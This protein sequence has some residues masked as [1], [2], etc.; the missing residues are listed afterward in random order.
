MSVIAVLIDTM[1]IQKYIFNSNYLKENLGASFIVEDIYDSQ[2]K[3]TIGELFPNIDRDNILEEW[4]KNPERIMINDENVEFEVG[5]LGGGNALLFFKDKGKAV[6]FIREWSKRLLVM[7]PGLK[8]AYA[9][10]E[11]DLSRFS[12]NIKKLFEQLRDNKNSVIPDVIIRRH[13]VS[14]ECRRTG[15]SMEVWCDKLPEGEN[16]YIS[17]ISNAKILAAEQS[18]IKVQRFLDDLKLSENYVFTDELEKL[19]Q[20][21]GEESHIAIVHIDGNDMGRRFREQSDLTNI[22]KLSK[23][24]KDATEN[25]FKNLIKEICNKFHI[26]KNNEFVFCREHNKDILPIRPIII[27]GDDITFVTDGRLG[28]YLAKIFLE[29]FERQQVSDKKPLSACAGV[30]ITKTKYPFYRGYELSEE[31]CKL[32]KERRRK[33]NDTGSWLDW[34]LVYSGISGSLSEIRDS[35]YKVLDKNLLMRPYKLTDLNE[36]IFSAKSLVIKDEKGK[37]IFPHS[38]LMKLRQILY[39]TKIEQSLFIEELEIRGHKLPVYDSFKNNEIF[40]NNTTPYYD[41]IDLTELYPQCLLLE[42]GKND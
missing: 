29:N 32:A 24:V 17:S 25:S 11:F 41:M 37:S 33:E 1:S 23:T 40:V 38:K 28:I 26:L 13:G 10:S 9:I 27:G 7:C 31:L 16:D 2:L 8:T 30:A 5:Y 39:S 19:G 18:K 34:H 42:G 35:Q 20:I 22:R 14:A 3:E 6:S 15:L 4:K 12:E 36:L 21:K